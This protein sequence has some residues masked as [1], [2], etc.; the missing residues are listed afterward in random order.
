MVEWVADDLFPSIFN[1]YMNSI[2]WL[3][4]YLGRKRR[5]K[6]EDSSEHNFESGPEIVQGLLGDYSYHFKEKTWYSENGGEKKR[7]QSMSKWKKV[8]K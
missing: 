8:K 1:V 7:G 6:E 4:V 3:G 2:W 5:T